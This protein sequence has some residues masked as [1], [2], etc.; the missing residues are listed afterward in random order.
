VL[1][2]LTP[3]HKVRIVQAFQRLGHVVGMTGDGA[4]DAAIR[5]VDVGVALGGC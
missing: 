2:R 1:A 4:N 5:L 3:A